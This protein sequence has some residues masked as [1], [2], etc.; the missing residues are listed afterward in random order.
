MLPPPLPRA[1]RVL[2]RARGA[3]GLSPAPAGQS[4][5]SISASRAARSASLPSCM[6]APTI[7]RWS[8]SAQGRTLVQ[9]SSAFHARPPSRSR[10]PRST[11]PRPLGP[12]PRGN[13]RP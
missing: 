11:A 3:I 8:A 1:D 6:R 12:S 4:R 10:V 9:V 13:S 2:G 7:Q 5:R